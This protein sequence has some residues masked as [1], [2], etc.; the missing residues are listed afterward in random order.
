MFDDS[1]TTEVKTGL[2]KHLANVFVSMFQ[3]QKGQRGRKLG[4]EA[5]LTRGGIVHNQDSKL[6]IEIEHYKRYDTDSFSLPGGQLESFIIRFRGRI[7]GRMPS[8]HTVLI[9]AGG[10]A[11]LGYCASVINDPACNDMHDIFQSVFK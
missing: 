6:T 8:E 9:D 11:H 2:I 4:I 1:L 10:T 5:D 3:W 7:E